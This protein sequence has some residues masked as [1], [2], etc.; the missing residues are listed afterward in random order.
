MRSSAKPS[1]CALCSA[2]SSVRATTCT[3]PARLR[4]GVSTIV[5]RS[6]ASAQSRAI[7]A[8][9]G[10]GG[11]RSTSSTNAARSL[12]S[13]YPSSSNSVSRRAIARPGPEASAWNAPLPSPCDRL[14]PAYW[15]AR[16][17]IT[18]SALCSWTSGSPPSA[19]SPGASATDP[20]PPMQISAIRRPASRPPRAAIPASTMVAPCSLSVT[21]RRSCGAEA[22]SPATRG[23]ASAFTLTLGPALCTALIISGDRTLRRLHPAG[24]QLP[25]CAGAHLQPALGLLRGLRFGEH[26]EHRGSGR[27]RRFPAGQIAAPVGETGIGRNPDGLVCVKDAERTARRAFPADPFGELRDRALETQQMPVRQAFGEIVVIE[28][29]R[30][31]RARV[32]L[33]RDRPAI[34]EHEVNTGQPAQAG[35]AYESIE[36]RLRSCAQRRCHGDVSD[37]S[38]I[39][40]RGLPVRRRA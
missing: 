18:G 23:A 2:T 1:A 3:V 16:H 17:A 6:A 33:D 10:S 34:G 9:T 31:R 30:R 35:D 36:A 14:Q 26:R 22:T 13:A 4:V 25:Y 15:L 39:A 27:D 38:P 20:N 37:R 12:R 32:D 28:L 19:P 40:E 29:E 7:L 8:M 24:E 5:I 21:P 11:T